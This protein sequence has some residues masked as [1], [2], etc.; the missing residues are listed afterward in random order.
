[1]SKVVF[2]ILQNN[3]YNPFQTYYGDIDSEIPEYN[4]HIWVGKYAQ[5]VGQFYQISL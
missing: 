5:K 3:V 4:V 2:N 1:M